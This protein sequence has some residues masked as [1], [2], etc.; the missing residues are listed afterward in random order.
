MENWAVGVCLKIRLES[1]PEIVTNA[2]L[3]ESVETAWRQNPDP[4]LERELDAAAA[5]EV[6]ETGVIVLDTF[7]LDAVIVLGA[8]VVAALE[9]I[10]LEEVNV[11]PPGQDEPYLSTN[12]G[13]VYPNGLP[14]PIC[15]TEFVSW[16]NVVNL[17]I[18]PLAVHCRLPDTIE[19]SN[20]T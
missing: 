14:V 11:D 17:Y 13:L 1:S 18:L 7:V 20:G 2:P 9:V 4:E 12:V 16:R 19:Q 3:L 6:D 15:S 8:E 5:L 10:G